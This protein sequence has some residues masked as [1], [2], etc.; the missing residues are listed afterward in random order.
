[1]ARYDLKF[2]AHRS[3]NRKQVVRS[4]GKVR[5]FQSYGSLTTKTSSKHQKQLFKDFIQAMVNINS[6]LSVK[7]KFPK[8]KIVGKGWNLRTSTDLHFNAIC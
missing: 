2:N 4:N 8:L 5:H 1:V 7:T 6:W 3:N